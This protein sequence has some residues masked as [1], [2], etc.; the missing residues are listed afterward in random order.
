MTNFFVMLMH[1]CFKV[2]HIL[3]ASNEHWRCKPEEQMV[4]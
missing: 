4:I 3:I 2:E 1:W